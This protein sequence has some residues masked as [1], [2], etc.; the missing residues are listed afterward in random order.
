[1]IDSKNT[2]RK[3]YTVLTLAEL[4]IAKLKKLARKNSS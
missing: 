3:Q 2:K 4:T 1:M